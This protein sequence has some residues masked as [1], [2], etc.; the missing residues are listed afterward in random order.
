MVTRPSGDIQTSVLISP[1][2]FQLCKEHNIKFSEA[3]RIGISIA[4]AEKGVSEYDNTLNLYRKMLLF[5]KKA[6]EA[7]AKLAELQMK[8]EQKV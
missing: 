6:E 8:Y 7:L 2:F 1:T 5:Q 3:I 4:L